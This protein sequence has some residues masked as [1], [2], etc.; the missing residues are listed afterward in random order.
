M[1]LFVNNIKNC[2][3]KGEE[4]GGIIVSSYITEFVVKNKRSLFFII[5]FFI[6]NIIS[7]LPLP[8]LSKIIIDDI[9]IPKNYEI[10]YKVLLIFLII[11]IIQVLGNYISN[12]LSIKLIQNYIYSLKKILY[13]KIFNSKVKFNNIDIGNSQT[14]LTNDT[15]VVAVYSYS[16]FWSISTNIVLLIAYS[17]IMFAINN[18]LFLI[19]VILM[20][21]VVYVYMKIGAKIEEKTTELQL[22]KDSTSTVIY[23]NLFNSREVKVNDIFNFRKNKIN[24]IFNQNKQ[25]SITQNKL[26]LIMN[27]IL[28]FVISIAPIII[29]IV[30][31]TFIKNGKISIGELITFVS[32]QGLMFSPIQSLMQSFSSYK[33]LV[34]SYNRLKYFLEESR[35]ICKVQNHIEK[36]NEIIINNFNVKFPWGDSLSV[37]KFSCREGDL[38]YI[39]GN[40]GV[41]KSLFANILSGLTDDCLDPVGK[42]TVPQKLS[43]LTGESIIYTDSLINNILLGEKYDIDKLDKIINMLNIKT[44]IANKE[45][46]IMPV[47]LSSGEKEKIIFA[48]ELYREPKFIIADEAF[49][50]I[51]KKT[52]N[53]IIKYC[54]ERK[55]SLI[56]ISHYDEILINL[57][58]VKQYKIEKENK[59][60]Y[61]EEV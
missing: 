55:I 2:Y 7:S 13:N 25:L 40:N 44:L 33:I 24:T 52:R 61:V 27:T 12:Y 15:S 50:S 47:S 45:Q 8:Y 56:I 41:G 57:R 23:E 49:S 51:D 6:I 1:F 14:I 29:F 21:F 48:R 17:F 34:V 59:N 26:I 22:N 30:G 18:I 42:L 3:N 20:P 60:I 53:N 36:N 10:L 54:L 31:I 4:L 16:I 58:E 37:P 28:S 46:I 43:L 39:S 38:I 35:D 32:Y 5:I 9:I 11:I 19:N